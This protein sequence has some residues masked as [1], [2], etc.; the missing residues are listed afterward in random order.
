MTKRRENKEIALKEKQWNIAIT[1]F[2]CKYGKVRKEIIKMIDWYLFYQY[3]S[4][5]D[6]ALHIFLWILYTLAGLRIFRF[7]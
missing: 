3:K 5:G 4:K 1:K 6:K 7:I 2:W